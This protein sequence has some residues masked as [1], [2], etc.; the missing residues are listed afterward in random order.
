M[1]P[2]R[3]LKHSLTLSLLNP[4][5][6]PPPPNSLQLITILGCAQIRLGL[7]EW[8]QYSDNGDQVPIAVL[9]IFWAL[10][11]VKS[12]EVFLGRFFKEEIQHSNSVKGS[13]TLGGTSRG[14]SRVSLGMGRR[15]SSSSGWSVMETAGWALEALGGR[16]G[17]GG[18]GSDEATVV[19]EESSAKGKGEGKDG[20][21]KDAVEGLHDESPDDLLGVSCLLSTSYFLLRIHVYLCS[22]WTLD[23]SRFVF[24]T[25]ADPLS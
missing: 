4:N 13:S 6:S 5:S 10:V 7:E 21:S 17:G 2:A 8:V 15:G 23:S 1:L 9:I 25:F 18:R 12:A 11:G 19:G 14:T 20:G 3:A 24:V 22:V 16:R